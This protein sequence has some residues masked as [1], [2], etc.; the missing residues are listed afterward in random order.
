MKH[1]R[2]AKPRR[3]TDTL[4]F[5]REAIRRLDRVAVDEF[6]MPSIILMENAAIRLC[7]TAKRMLGKKASPRVAIFC[8]PG[9][10]GG[11]GLALARH[12]HNAGARVRIILAGSP[13]RYTE[14]AAANVKIVQAMKLEVVGSRSVIRTPDLIVDALLGTGVDRPV[15]GE[16]AR[17]IRAI[18]TIGSRGSPVLSVD[19]PSGLDADTGAPWGNAVRADVTLTLVG[20]KR[21]FLELAARPYLGRV[22]V[23]D[24]GVP[25]ELAVRLGTGLVPRRIGRGNTGKRAR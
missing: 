6:G 2:N 11:D 25:R 24:I 18:N 1:A 8:G 14:G 4:V 3:A 7:E 5:T 21:G 15:E 19:I 9:N 22:E 13:E 20:F 16:V 23:G 10:N 12:L 17:L